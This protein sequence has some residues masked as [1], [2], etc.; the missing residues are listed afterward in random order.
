VPLFGQAE[1]AAPDRNDRPTISDYARRM[2][3][4]VL[5]MLAGLTLL[6]S[7]VVRR[8]GLRKAWYT[9]AILVVAF[10][11]L[12]IWFLANVNAR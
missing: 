7:Q 5:V 3:F 10:I 1:V 11:A 9:I 6:V 2:V 8:P 12:S 4:G